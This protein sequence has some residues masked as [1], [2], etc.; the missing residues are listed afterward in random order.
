MEN[1]SI[2]SSI[3]LGIAFI[4]GI[5]IISNTW[6]SVKAADNVLSV[7]GSAKKAVVSDIVKWHTSFSRTVYEAALKTGY[8]QMKSDEA[9]VSAFLKKNGVTDAE[10]TISPVSMNEIYGYNKSAGEPV[11]YQLF[12]SVSIQSSDIQKIKNLSG[13]IE[14]IINQGV[15]FSNNSPEYYYSK[16]PEVRVELLS[17]AVKDAKVRAD[18][19]AASTGKKVG[20]IK[21][22]SMGVVQVL[23]PNSTD[24]SDYGNY[25]TST[26]EKEIMV[27]VKTSFSLK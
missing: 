15:L 1:K 13:N 19:I 14:E 18:N 4:I 11:E 6:F 5:F 26:I 27:T 24:I 21:S 20:S 8:A 10:M 22:A 9:A 25:D 7:T 2:F 3:V 16:L 17:D 23:Q 12:Q